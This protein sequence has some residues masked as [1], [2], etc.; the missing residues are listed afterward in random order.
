VRHPTEYVPCDHR[1][2]P[3]CGE[4]AHAHASALRRVP[5]RLSSLVAP[6]QQGALSFGNKAF[7]YAGSDAKVRLPDG[8]AETV[9]YRMLLPLADLDAFIISKS[10]VLCCLSSRLRDK[11]I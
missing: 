7:K 6:G 1:A 2:S 3:R 8:S 4:A 11:P 5:G 10:L 9:H